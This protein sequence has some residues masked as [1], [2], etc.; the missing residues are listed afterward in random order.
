MVYSVYLTFL[1]HKFQNAMAF[2]LWPNCYYLSL[3]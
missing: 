2:T 1:I 3:G